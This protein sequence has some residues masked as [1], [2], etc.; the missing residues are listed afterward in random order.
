VPDD[1]YLV[2]V[3]E[4]TALVGDGERWH[5]IGAGGVH[6]H[7]AND[8]STFANGDALALALTGAATS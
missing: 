1:D 2:G 7:A 4:Q 6:V 3:D 5:V 8:W